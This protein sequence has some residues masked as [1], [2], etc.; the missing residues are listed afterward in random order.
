M[1]TVDFVFAVG[2]MS[3]AAGFVHGSWFCPWQLVLSVA[4]G[5]VRCSSFGPW[6]LAFSAAASFVRSSWFCPWQL[7]L[8]LVYDILLLSKRWKLSHKS[9]YI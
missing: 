1:F 4:A 2:N 9:K 7:V 6:Q 3:A 5:F 8:S